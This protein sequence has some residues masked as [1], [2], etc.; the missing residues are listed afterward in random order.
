MIY[1][2]VVED[3]GDGYAANR[4]FRTNEEA[5]AYIELV[6]NE[7]SDCACLNG[8]DKIDTDSPDFFHEDYE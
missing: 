2:E 8:V 6:N 3:I 5:E 4:R 7:D 1:Y